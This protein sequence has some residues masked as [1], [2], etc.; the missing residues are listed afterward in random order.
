VGILPMTALIGAMLLWSSAFIALKY[1]LNFFH[2]AQIVF[3]RMLIASAVLLIL[4]RG[5]FKF[6]YQPGDWR[7]LLMMGAAEP[8][9]YFLLETNALRYTSAGQAGVINATLPLLASVGAYLLLKERMTPWAIAGFL[10]ALLGCSMLSI[11]ASVTDSASAPLLGNFLEF[12]AMICGA[13]YSL[14]VR[15]LSVRYSAMAL[16]AFQAGVGTLFFAPLALQTSLPTGVS[17]VQWGWL[18]YMATCITVGA[19]W[20][21]NW[22][23]SRVSV[24]LA[25]AYINLIPVF[26]LLLA[27]VILDEQLNAWQCLAC[28]IVFIGIVVSQCRST[29]PRTEAGESDAQPIQTIDQAAK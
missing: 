24:A 22:A 17:W 18:V 6:C 3:V 16:T 28:I 11:M 10:I 5:R 20:L 9:L 1:L 26:T 12:L 13:V 7:W 14:A 15:R 25:T 21:Y 4:S 29:S 2:P 23:M 27:F 19:Y 8:C